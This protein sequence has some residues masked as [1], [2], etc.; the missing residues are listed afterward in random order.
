MNIIFT[1]SDHSYISIENFPK[2]DLFVKQVVECV[3][4][5]S[6]YYFTDANED[7]QPLIP[8]NQNP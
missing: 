2:R 7:Q 1:R 5:I 6:L 4:D 8:M 3:F